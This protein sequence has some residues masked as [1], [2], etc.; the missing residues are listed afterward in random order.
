M[1][2]DEEEIEPA[3]ANSYRPFKVMD[4]AIMKHIAEEIEALGEAETEGAQPNT[5]PKCCADHEC[6]SPSAL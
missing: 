1:P 4:S 2:V 3:D 6:Q 5:R